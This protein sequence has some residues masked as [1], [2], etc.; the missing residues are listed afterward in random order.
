MRVRTGRHSPNWLSSYQE[1]HETVLNQFK[2]REFVESD[3]LVFL[4]FSD[5]YGG[6]A[7][8]LL[9]GNIACLGE[10]LIGVNKFIEILDLYETDC[11]VQTRWYSYNVSIQGHGNLLRY[12]NQDPDYDFRSGHQDEHHKH[13]FDWRLNEELPGS[14]FWMGE[15]DWPT[16]GQV[17]QEVQDWYWDNRADLRNPD[18]YATLGLTNTP[19]SL[20]L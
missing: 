11:K 15:K 9:S 5:E 12:D 18:S 3:D 19:P 1:T 7:G 20:E 10:I 17:L 2:S 13:R 4:P 14:P 16:L 6:E 8:I